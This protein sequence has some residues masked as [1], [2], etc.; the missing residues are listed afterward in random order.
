MKVDM[1]VSLFDSR[2]NQNQGLSQQIFGYNGNL[3]T[4]FFLP[5]QWSLRASFQYNGPRLDIQG[6]DV[7]Y[8][9]LR[10]SIRKN[11]WDNKLNASL[12]FDDIARSVLQGGD[13]SDP[14]FKVSSRSQRF[15]PYV[16]LR[17]NY[18]LGELKD[19]PKSRK[20]GKQQ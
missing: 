9:I 6:V 10:A 4:N 3:Q 2:M 17:L 11:L 18:R 5:K 8:Y 19:M 12:N 14:A 13:W 16:S 1:S 15:R 7:S 20:A